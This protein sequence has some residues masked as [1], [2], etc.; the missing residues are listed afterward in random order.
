MMALRVLLLG[1]TSEARALAAHLVDDGAEVTSSLAGRVTDPA[2]P[3][4]AVRIGGFGGIE[5]LKSVLDDYDV[6]ID[7]THPFA[8]GISANAAAACEERPLLRLERPGWAA[9]SNPSWRWVDSHREAADAA[10]ELGERPLLTIGRQHLWEFVPALRDHRVL[11]RVVDEPEHELPATWQL[12]RSRGPY[13]LEREL[14]LLADHRSDVLVTK[15]SGGDYTWP[16]MRAA[17]QRKVP[18]VI[19]RRP[20]PPVGISVVETVE[21]A[22]S[23]VRSY[24]QTIGKLDMPVNSVR[25]REPGANPGLARSGVGM[26]TR[27]TR[28]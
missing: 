5:G 10:A 3:V 9:R 14:A 27:A 18:V 26:T 1:G 25:R 28:N 4:G 22:L 24:T 12:L 15:D 16:K 21:D 6:V 7:A 11:A 23:W 13:T 17:E 8:A 2:M 20:S 19:V